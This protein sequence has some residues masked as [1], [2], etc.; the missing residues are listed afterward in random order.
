VLP[1]LAVEARNQPR[2]RPAASQR[3]DPRGPAAAV[4][5]TLPTERAG[6]LTGL[7][8]CDTSLLPADFDRAFRAAG[9][10]HLM[11]VSGGSE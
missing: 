4:P 2:S 11:A 7:S 9:L 3:D 5:A 10:T 6:L 1:K 8:L